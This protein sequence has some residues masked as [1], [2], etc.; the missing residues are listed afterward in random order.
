MSFKSSISELRSRLNALGCD[1]ST[2]GLNGED[3]REEL[4]RRLEQAEGKSGISGDSNAFSNN[5]SIAELRERL[6]AL[7]ENT[8]TP[9]LM[10]EERRQEL[11]RRLVRSVCGVTDEDDDVVEVSKVVPVAPQPDTSVSLEETDYVLPADITVTAAP[12][13]KPVPPPPPRKPPVKLE[14]AME[15]VPQPRP[16]EPE[17]TPRVVATQAEI[18]E[19]KKDLRRISNKRAIYVASKLSG[20]NQD[21]AL[22]ESEKLASWTDAEMARLRQ[23]QQKSKTPSTERGSSLLIDNG[24]LMGIEKVVAK[25]EILRTDAKDQIRIHR[26]RVRAE[27]DGS[28]EFGVAVEER[29]KSALSDAVINKGLS[30]GRTRQRID[31]LTD[32]G[33]TITKNL[34]PGDNETKS[35][36]PGR[37]LGQAAQMLSSSRPPTAEDDEDPFE[38]S[39]PTLNSKKDPLIPRKAGQSHKSKKKAIPD[40]YDARVSHMEAQGDEQMRGFEELLAELEME[41]EKEKFEMEMERNREN[42]MRAVKDAQPVETWGVNP[43]VKEIKIKYD[44]PPPTT[45]PPSQPVSTLPSSRPCSSS[46]SGKG[47]PRS[48]STSSTK[49]AK[50]ALES[51]PPPP[52]SPPLQQSAMPAAL[53]RIKTPDVGR[54]DGRDLGLRE[55]RDDDS[56]DGDLQEEASDDAENIP[57]PHPTRKDVA[58][59]YSHLDEDSDDDDNNPIASSRAARSNVN[60]IAN[61]DLEDDDEEMTSLLLKY[62]QQGSV[63]EVDE[64]D[65]LETAQYDRPNTKDA[66]VSK[67]SPERQ[68]HKS[69]GADASQVN[70]T[71]TVQSSSESPFKVAPAPA[72]RAAGNV[73]KRFASV[74]DDEDQDDEDEE[75]E[76]DTSANKREII[77]LRRQARDLERNGDLVGADNMHARA[78]ELD[79]LD[80]RSLEAY[81]LFLHTR[82]GEIAR[83]DSF[84]N[85]AV[86][87]CIPDLLQK[88]SPSGKG[89]VAPPA[90]LLRPVASP[91]KSISASSTLRVKTVI[92]LL[93]TYANF[94]KRSKGDIEGAAA[95]YFKAVEI[96]PDHAK[97]LASCGHFLCEEGGQKNI[98]EALALFARALRAA[99]N[100]VTHALWYAKLLRRCG[101]IAQADIMYQVA[102]KYSSGTDRKIEP[103]A[104]CNYA[105]FVYRQRKSPEKAQQLFLEGLGRFPWHKGLLRNYGSLLKAVPALKE[106][107]GASSL[108]R[109]STAAPLSKAMK[110]LYASS[111]PQCSPKSSKQGAATGFFAH[112]SS[113]SA[114]APNPS[115]SASRPTS[116]VSNKVQSSKT[117]VLSGSFSELRVAAS[118]AAGEKDAEG[119]FEKLF[120][121]GDDDEDDEDEEDLYKPP[122]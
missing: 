43:Y 51:R 3:R 49:L 89:K 55:E 65:E 120:Y 40:S 31:E 69:V 7:G 12:K 2:P 107:E 76:E 29:I 44:R 102:Y 62:P 32:K 122:E 109:N 25:L 81:A 46:S 9:G 111:S 14:T 58:V 1:T 66:A 83:A 52:S 5:L 63:E 99:P 95:V 97:A 41:E 77:A 104:I 101:R 42:E 118:A 35:G 108:S 37:L 57:T 39:F 34:R 15:L 115:P 78:L 90:E 13:F 71:P 53:P 94:L 110:A 48:K 106:N 87:V 113:V 117:D 67:S 33:E 91:P 84:F 103:T 27:A 47:T 98:E 73:A 60:I 96:A 100:N 11:M 30:L 54:M 85:R 59:S 6:S 93:L 70:K 24:I 21:P 45:R 114:R 116:N 10:G 16:A 88:L 80:I 112:E 23:Q 28:A 4:A 79:P 18:S 8:S 61:V 75:E 26:L 22:K 72:A 17:S 105:T 68:P 56:G 50:I 86:H 20:A 82:K 64:D 119:A 121:R 38:S 92:H 36:M 74:D 19:M